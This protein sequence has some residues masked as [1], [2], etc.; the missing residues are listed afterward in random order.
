M[1]WERLRRPWGQVG[2]GRGTG[3]G[4]TQGSPPFFPATPAPTGRTRFPAR[5]TNYLPLREGDT[6]EAARVTTSGTLCPARETLRCAQGDIK[7]NAYNRDEIGDAEQ[8][9]QQKNQATQ[10]SS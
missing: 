1:E 2:S 10:A 6:R 7:G 9:K 3:R 4:A 8:T 5:F